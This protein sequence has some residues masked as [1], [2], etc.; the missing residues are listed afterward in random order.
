M[1]NRTRRT[2]KEI[3]ELKAF[4]HNCEN[5]IYGSLIS[6]IMAMTPSL[7]DDVYAY[8]RKFRK[9]CLPLVGDEDFIKKVVSAY[10]NEDVYNDFVVGLPLA[11]VESET[12]SIFMPYI[13]KDGEKILMPFREDGSYPAS[14]GYGTTK[15]IDWSEV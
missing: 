4:R 2:K 6:S 3:K 9:I 13:E 12:N 15:Y 10:W 5:T 7:R 1:S 8:E 11:L 14:V